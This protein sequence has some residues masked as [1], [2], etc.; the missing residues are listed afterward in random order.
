MDR[1]CLPGSGFSYDSDQDGRNYGARDH[2]M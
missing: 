2:P 1:R